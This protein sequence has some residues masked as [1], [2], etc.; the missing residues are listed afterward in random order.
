MAATAP[1]LSTTPFGRPVVPDVYSMIAGAPAVTAT[2]PA[3]AAPAAS[4]RGVVTTR[5]PAAA[6][7]RESS[8]GAAT[9]RAGAA[10]PTM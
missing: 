9:I 6:L 10:L 7:A 3:R 8:S 2:S 1:W 5:G 4:S